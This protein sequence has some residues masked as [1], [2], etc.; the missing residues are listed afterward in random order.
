[1]NLTFTTYYLRHLHKISRT[2]GAAK[3]TFLLVRPIRI[4]K[5]LQESHEQPATAHKLNER[6]IFK[7]LNTIIDHLRGYL[8]EYN[9]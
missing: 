8:G 1:M 3:V 2:I 7:T 4:L 6:D 9:W 5:E